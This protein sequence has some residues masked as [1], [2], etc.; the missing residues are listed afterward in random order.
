MDKEKVRIKNKKY[1][2]A[3]KE[4]IARK[5]KL[6]REANKVKIKKRK[7]LY[8]EANK[9]KIARYN[10]K[11]APIRNARDRERYQNEPLYKLSMAIK[12]SIKH[13]IRNNGY[14]KSTRSGDILGCSFKEFKKHIESQ[15]EPWMDWDNYGLYSGEEGYGWDLDHIIPQCSA[16]NEGKLLKLN[17]YTNFQP[18]C[19]YINRDIKKDQII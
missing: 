6:Y 8:R 15:W 18:L 2:E 19:S 5:K 3:N 9:E 16:I 1:R 14:I 12:N 10:K 11:Y 7:K 17:H 4:E 13:S